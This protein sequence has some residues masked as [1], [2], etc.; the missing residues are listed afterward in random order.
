MLLKAVQLF[1][2]FPLINLNLKIVWGEY[3]KATK[4]YK[5]IKK[6]CIIMKWKKN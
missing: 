2:I 5:A 1:Q 3:Y 6:F 4:S